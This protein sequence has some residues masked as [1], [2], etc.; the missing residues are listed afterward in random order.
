MTSFRFA[1][2]LT[3]FVLASLSFAAS[4]CD[5]ETTA[6][7]D[8]SD[9][10]CQSV[11][12]SLQSDPMNC[13]ACG[14]ICSPSSVCVGGE[15]RNDSPDLGVPD[16]DLSDAG[17]NDLGGDAMSS[18]DMGSMC[19]SGW[20]NCD[21]N[22]DCEVGGDFDVAQCGSCSNAC[23]Y[24]ADCVGGTCGCVG[25]TTECSDGC[26]NLIS[27]SAHCGSCTTACDPGEICD[28]GRCVV[29]E[30]PEGSTL[31]SGSCVLLGSDRYNCGECGN[32]CASDE[33]CSGGRCDAADTTSVGCADGMRDGFRDATAFPN[34]AACSGG[35]T[36]PGVFP[37]PERTDVPTCATTGDDA[38]TNAAGTDCSAADLCG[39]GWHICRGGE[40]GERTSGM[41]CNAAT[42]F[43]AQSFY[44]ASVSGTGCDHCALPT[45]TGL[46]G[47]T[48]DSCQA[49]CQ[50]SPSLNNDLFGC[51]HGNGRVIGTSEAAACDGLNTSGSDECTGLANDPA[52]SCT[53]SVRESQTITRVP[54]TTPTCVGTQSCSGGEV[55]CG[56]ADGYRTCTDADACSGILDGVEVPDSIK[57]GG[58][59]CCR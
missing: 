33:R 18:E 55:C 40:I 52:W 46:D 39:A 47:C 29:A 36:V 1:S 3:S 49:G 20:L 17:V 26:F 5:D 53:G 41:S 45:N 28:F 30:C 27:N 8:G 38:A 34:I 48:A 11:C 59:L 57:E 35:F 7:C 6:A 56:T 9:V 10:I 23:A 2:I 21:S 37:S 32:T 13:G 51:G 19:P 14:V 15:C 25:G 16:A 4:G 58:V 50:Q 44:A 42:D 43:P 22:P 24:G 31:C 12:T 54:A